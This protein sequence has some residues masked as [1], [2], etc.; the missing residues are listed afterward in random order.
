MVYMTK[1]T[2][3]LRKC[4]KKSGGWEGGG[5]VRVDMNKELKLLLKL[6]KKLRGPVEVY[7]G[8]GLRVDAND[9]LKLLSKCRKKRRKKGLDRVLFGGGG[10]G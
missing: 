7:G 2:K 10:R 1:E 3:L 5:G 4:L 6:Q 9:E 8:V